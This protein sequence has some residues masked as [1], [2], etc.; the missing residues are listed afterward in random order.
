MYVKLNVIGSYK[1]AFLS[2]FAIDL[3]PRPCEANW[4]MRTKGATSTCR[5]PLREVIRVLTPDADILVSRSWAEMV[6]LNPAECEP[7][8]SGPNQINIT[9][10][11]KEGIE[12]AEE[13]VA[14]IQIAVENYED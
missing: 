13:P 1:N 9:K 3:S 11:V 6:G 2:T 12:Q 8:N 7:F 4:V 5:V 10:M 14:P